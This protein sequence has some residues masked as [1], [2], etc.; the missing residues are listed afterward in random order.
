ML[1]NSG[2]DGVFAAAETQLKAI[3]SYLK[4][5]IKGIIKIPNLDKKG[6]VKKAKELE[7]VRDFARSLS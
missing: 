7:Q 3:A 1:L 6:S 4:W 2:G 5:E